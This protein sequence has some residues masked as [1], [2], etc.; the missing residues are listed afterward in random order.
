MASITNDVICRTI[1]EHVS[2]CKS[3]RMQQQG[4]LP[5]NMTKVQEHIHKYRQEHIKELDCQEKS[6]YAIVET[7]K[8][9]CEDIMAQIRFSQVTERVSRA[10]MLGLDLPEHV[11]DWFLSAI[12]LG[13]ISDCI[14]ARAEIPT[15]ALK[16]LSVG[17]ISSAE[18]ATIQ[19]FWTTIQQEKEVRWMSLDEETA[20]SIVCETFRVSRSHDLSRLFRIGSHLTQE[21]EDTFFTRMQMQS[22]LQKMMLVYSSQI[23]P[24]QV[25]H[26]AREKYIMDAIE[27]AGFNLLFKVDEQKRITP[28]FAMMQILLDVVHQEQATT[29]RPVLN[30]SATRDIIYNGCTNTRDMAIPFPGIDLPL[31]AH[32]CFAPVLQFS[33][34]DFYHA[35]LTGSAPMQDKHLLLRIA[36]I[37]DQIAQQWNDDMSPYMKIFNDM[38]LYMKTFADDLIDLEV[39]NYVVI[40]EIDQAEVNHLNHTPIEYILYCYEKISKEM[41]KNQ[42]ENFLRLFEKCLK[43]LSREDLFALNVRQSQD[44]Q[45]FVHWSGFLRAFAY[46]EERVPNSRSVFKHAVQQEFMLWADEREMEQ[47]TVERALEQM[48]ERLLLGSQH[49]L[50]RCFYHF[51]DTVYAELREPSKLQELFLAQIRANNRDQMCIVSKDESN[52]MSITIQ[53]MAYHLAHMP[54]TQL[55][56]LHARHNAALLYAN[57]KPNAVL[58]AIYNE[59]MARVGI[60]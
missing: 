3:R 5:C 21:Q 47:D 4:V 25:R 29:I 55:I 46:L 42:T 41:N 52:E 12:K 13:D 53:N 19:L 34:H 15:I 32:D 18:F 45:A 33:V 54:L 6:R 43:R 57:I 37:V 56:D 30:L 51:Y 59:Q 14:W 60:D 22:P 27:E 20:R 1:L 50:E 28:S 38:C 16:A 17:L 40:T 31:L 7:A 44:F 8:C 39:A 35:F 9:E 58:T 49:Q 10:F 26:L 36:C 23:P 11:P 48:Y 24:R 2:F